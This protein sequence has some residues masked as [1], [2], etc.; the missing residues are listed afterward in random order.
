MPSWGIVNN[1]EMIIQM[2]CW[3][4]QNVWKWD[5]MKY[6]EYWCGREF[7]GLGSQKTGI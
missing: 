1:R 7:K 3:F 4:D 5:E 2:E 6:E